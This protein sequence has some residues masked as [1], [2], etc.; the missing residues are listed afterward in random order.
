MFICG[1]GGAPS[2]AL[3]VL[4]QLA[5]CCADAAHD[6]PSACSCWEMEFDVDQAPVDRTLEPGTRTSMCTDCAYRVPADFGGH[7][8]LTDPFWCHQGMRKP[9]RYRHPAGI[10]V[11]ARADHY[12]PPLVQRDDGLVIPYKADGTP[13][14]R[15][16]GWVS[17]RLAES[18]SLAEL[19]G[20][21]QE[22]LDG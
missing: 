15:C 21:A 11:E 18:R 22:A 16:A 1:A 7:G 5:Y 9:V 14:D 6:G 12:K 19:A 17:W 20:E 10:I 4:T 2:D 8:S 3:R 13:G